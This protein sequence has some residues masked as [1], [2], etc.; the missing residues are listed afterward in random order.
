MNIRRERYKLYAKTNYINV[1]DLPLYR[2][3]G[4]NVTLGHNMF[5]ITEKLSSRTESD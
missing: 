3:G 4:D 2:S 1:G 5:C